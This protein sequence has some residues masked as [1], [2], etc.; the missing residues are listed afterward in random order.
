MADAASHKNRL[1][2][3]TS[4]YLLQHQHNP[5]DW[6]PWGPAA[7][8]EAQR[9]NRPILLSVGYAAC[10]WCHVMAHESFED[11]ATAAVMNELFVNIKVDR[12]ERPD[13]DQI[14][15]NALHHLGQQGGWP[16]TMFLT[17]DGAPFWGGTYFPKEAQYGR[18]GFTKVLREVARVFHE[19]PDK[20]NQ[21]RQALVA[22]LAHR[23]RAQ[24]P[25]TIGNAE[26]N[27]AA[28]SIAGATDPV[29]G[30]LRGAPKFPQCA[31][32]EFLWRAGTRTGDERFFITTNLALTRISQGGI[33]DHLGG[34]YA[35]YSVD[36]RWLVPH[37]EKMLYDNAQLLDLLALEHARAPNPLYAERAAETVGWLQREMMQA[38]GGL[39]SSLDADSEGEEGKFYV[40]SADEIAH[41]LGADNAAL[42]AAKYDVSLE[43][44]FEGQN[45][46]N[47][48]NGLTDT[49]AEA[50]RLAMLRDM[51]RQARSKRV[52]PGLDDK[53]LADWNGL[54]MAALTHAALAFERPDWLAMAR[55]AFAFV[56]TEMSRGDRLG[57][58]WRDGRLMFP[59]LASD[60]AAM[61]RAALSL[62]EATGETDI[63][64][65]AI[66]WQASLD[67]HYADRDHG[68]Y[69]LTA[70][71]AEGLI[72]RPHA[73]VDDAIP[74]HNGLIAQNLVRLAVLTGDDRYRQQSDALFAALL[75]VA[76]DNVFGH[77]S[78][79]NAL[80]LKL[81]GAE[82][83]VVGDGADANILL[84]AARRLPHATRIVLHAPQVSSLP[85]NHP[86]RAKADRVQDAAA[87]VCRGQSCSL[88]VTDAHAL[89]NLT[90]SPVG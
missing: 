19:A 75:P 58:S 12:E 60:H 86:A 30:G 2:R 34:G 71:D 15:M 5:V 77:L 73:T 8:A 89:K 56:A 7:L 35:R 43:G 17:P 46:L 87:F 41:V 20:V 28:V 37:F 25:A 24:N 76:Q 16:L 31:M 51:L 23:G 59:G 11:D 21:N 90:Q 9:S 82:I 47:R 48:L 42:F 22:R 78:L 70:D 55:R 18:P 38:E 63:L 62:F 40:W 49:P 29:N 45:I 33:Y 53:V 54:T 36:E 88:P 39:S 85:D 65:R 84:A 44:N 83:V 52:P 10:H 3:E 61:I 64:S 79:L 66:A 74:N 69:F 27:N 26:L 32:L 14:Y 6:W 72:V 68:G 13:I 4:P 81:N 80:D 1:A 50:K 57:H 67:T